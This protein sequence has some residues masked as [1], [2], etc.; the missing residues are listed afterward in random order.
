MKARG[1]RS[2]LGAK[3]L[4]HDE[5]V[6]R[7]G[8]NGSLGGWEPFVVGLG[9]CGGHDLRH[10]TTAGPV[11]P[12]LGEGQAGHAPMVPKE[13]VREAASGSC[14]ETTARNLPFGPRGITATSR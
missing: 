2:H 13:V 10:G 7:V 3:K 11:E 14:S 5:D 6:E 1:R 8:H 9:I 4:A 12:E